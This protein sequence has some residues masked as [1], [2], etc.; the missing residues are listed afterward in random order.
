MSMF[1]SASREPSSQATIGIM[2]SDIRLAFR[3]MVRRPAL[4]L[5]VIVTLALGTGANT[6]IFG[7]ASAILLRPLPGRHPEEL[8]RVLNVTSDGRRGSVSYPNYANYRESGVFADLAAQT[9]TTVGLERNGEVEQFFAQAVSGNYFKVFGIDVARGRTFAPEEDVPNGPCFVVVSATFRQGAVGQ[10]LKLNGT[11]CTVIG[12]TPAGFQ[13]TDVV[14]RVDVWVPLAPAAPW[15][16]PAFLA[17]RKTGSLEVLGRRKPGMS[18]AQTQAA[19]SRLASDLDRAY[20]ENRGHRVRV[21]AARAFD[22]ALRGPVEAFFAVVLAVTGLVLLT[23]CANLANLLLVRAVSRRREIAIRLALGASRVR[24]VRQMVTETLLLALAGGAAGMLLAMW[25]DSL[26][27]RFNPLPPSIPI[28]LDLTPDARVFG[29]AFALSLATGLI[30]GLIPALQSARTAPQSVL[31]DEAG[32]VAQGQSPLRNFFVIAQVAA[33]LVLLVGAGLFLRSLANASEID[34]GFTLRDGL[35]MELDVKRKNFTPEQGQRFYSDLLERER[36]LPGVTAAAWADFT[37]LDLGTARR[38]VQI[39]GFVPPPSQ[40]S[41]RLSS[42]LVSPG[43]FS[44]VGTPLVSGRDFSRQATPAGPGVAI[45]NQTMAKRFWPQKDPLGQRFQADGVVVQVVGVARDAKY[46]SLGEPAEAHF[47]LPYGQRT[48]S[49]RTLLVRTAGDPA[50][51]LGAVE[52]EIQHA[53]REV[54]PSFART[55]EQHLA[56]SLFPAR[57]AAAMSTLFGALALLLAATGIYGVVSYSVSLRTRE[58]GIRMALG[59]QPRDVL[60]LLMRQ[61]GRLIGVGVLAGIAASL[62][63]DRFLATLLYGLSPNDPATYAAVA[64]FLLVVA[65]SAG[66]WPARRATHVDPLVALRHD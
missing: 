42:N 33:S 22:G 23:A 49:R 53:D 60:S 8:V 27:L 56:L 10:A 54:L 63:L 32:A 50:G 43:F 17:D 44:T 5:M 14:G 3:L 39:E 13:G 35:T 40:D 34:L 26:L 64:L 48:E 57:A 66:Y 47:Y 4:T 31:K 7:V 21:V 46:R 6:V 25:A 30:L 51:L 11:T 12:V 41:L 55:V 16:G 20:P 37:P 2:H 59:A 9:L 18:V 29:F 65:L 19:M 58:I 28:R 36:A 24:L 38:P 61:G 62:A 52:A 1:A 45:V 15:I